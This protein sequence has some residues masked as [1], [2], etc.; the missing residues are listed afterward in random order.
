[1]SKITTA[2][3]PQVKYIR[4]PSV[5]EEKEINLEIS[6]E[7]STPEEKLPPTHL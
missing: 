7:T 6:D 4:K 5:D 3:I 2:K 1:M